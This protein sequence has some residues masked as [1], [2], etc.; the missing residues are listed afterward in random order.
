MSKYPRMLVRFRSENHDG[1]SD[2]N[3]CDIKKEY[4]SFVVKVAAAKA[5]GYMPAEA[6]FKELKPE[7][8]KKLLV[9]DFDDTRSIM[10]GKYCLVNHS[11]E[12]YRI[13]FNP[14]EPHLFAPSGGIGWKKNDEFDSQI[15]LSLNDCFTASEIQSDKR[16]NMRTDSADQNYNQLVYSKETHQD[17]NQQFMNWQDWKT[18]RKVDVFVPIDG[19]TGEEQLNQNSW[20]NFHVALCGKLSTI[21]FY[22]E[23]QQEYS[24]VLQTLISRTVELK[25]YSSELNNEI[26]RLREEFLNNSPT[27]RDLFIDQDAQITQTISPDLLYAARTHF[28]ELI[29]VELKNHD[30]NF[31]D[32]L[33][34]KCINYYDRPYKQGNY[35][36]FAA[37]QNF[38]QI[39]FYQKL[40]I[41]IGSI[42]SLIGAGLMI[43]HFAAGLTLLLGGLGGLGLSRN[44]GVRQQPLLNLN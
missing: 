27:M 15:R 2:L 42:L 38:N 10:K 32:E 26:H 36:F 19:V 6:A 20:N 11:N 44:L 12:L 3:W 30:L 18:K 7:L 24:Q 16:L 8:A 34:T 1:W 35:C 37:M 13:E 22:T 4:G 31:K 28:L 25:N 9:I 23:T 21:K 33:K 43:F 5:A 14:V 40:G 39:N 29:F 17:L 41:I